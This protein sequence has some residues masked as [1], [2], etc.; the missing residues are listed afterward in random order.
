MIMM[1]YR[2]PLNLLLSFVRV[3]IRQ[4]LQK[5]NLKHHQ[6]NTIGHEYFTICSECH[7]MERVY[8]F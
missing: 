8:G 2:R 4:K 5:E 7:K 3:D 6:H 1:V